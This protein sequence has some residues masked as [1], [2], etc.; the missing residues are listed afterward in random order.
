MGRQIGILLISVLWL[1]LQTFY[2]LN[3]LAYNKLENELLETMQ[4][5][6]KAASL[7][8]AVTYSR[9][10]SIMFALHPEADPY[11]NLILKC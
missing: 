8:T 1:I 5:V 7:A 10:L 6:P 2:S 4:V 3:Q 11:F 9:K